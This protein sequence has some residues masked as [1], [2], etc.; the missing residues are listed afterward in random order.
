MP[1]FL[2]WSWSP[3]EKL[4]AGWQFDPQQHTGGVIIY[5]FGEQRYELQSNRGRNPIWLSDS[6]R[7][8]SADVGKMYLFDIRSGQWR[9]LYNVEPG[10]FGTFGL[11]RDNR[12]LYYSLVSSEADIWQVSL[13]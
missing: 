6:K 3:D 5:S 8:I 9:D 7:L 10:G 2:P 1:G 12:R 11:S 4:L 13:N